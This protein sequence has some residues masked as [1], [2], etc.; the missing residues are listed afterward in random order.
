[1]PRNRWSSAGR[2]EPLPRHQYD[3]LACLAAELG[4]PIVLDESLTRVG[5]LTELA[6]PS[7]QWIVNIRVSKMG[8]LLRSLAV[9]EAARATGVGVIVGAQVGETSLLTRAGL[10]VAA[11]A[12][13]ALVAQEGAF[14]THL[15]AEDLCDPPLMFGAGGV[16]EVSATPSLAASGLGRFTPNRAWLR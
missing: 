11:A 15:L 7:S 4:C 6:A 10:T 8:G 3:A 16:L 5:Q 1:M 2:P 13:G 9:V 14:G 12:G